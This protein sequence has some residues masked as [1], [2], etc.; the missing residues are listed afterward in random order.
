MLITVPPCLNF[1]SP[2]NENADVNLKSTRHLVN[3]TCQSADRQS[4]PGREGSDL[5]IAE[6]EEVQDVAWTP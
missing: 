6:F 4:G 1:T 5:G 2:R 3:G